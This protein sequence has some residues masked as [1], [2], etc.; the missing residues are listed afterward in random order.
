MSKQNPEQ[1]PDT[2]PANVTLFESDVGE[3]T[4]FLARQALRSFESTESTTA[5][6]NE[7]TPQ[8]LL[9]AL[10]GGIDSTALLLALQAT[11][12]SH[13]FEIH[14]AHFNH[15]LRDKESLEDERYCTKL[16][17]ELQVPFHTEREVAA[18]IQAEVQGNP[19]SENALRQRRYAFLKR[20]TEA[21]GAK[22]IVTGHNLNDQ[23]ETVLFRLVRGTALA[24]ASGMKSWRNIGSQA[25]LL[26]PLLGM[27]RA[28]ISQYVLE[29]EHIAR[30]DSSNQDQRYSRNYIRQ[31]V[32]PHLLERFPSALKKLESFACAAAVDED[33]L[34]AVARKSFVAQ[35]LEADRW[36]LEVLKQM[37]QAILDRIIAQ[38][39][40]QRAIEVSA[41]LIEEI[42]S[43]IDKDCERERK[44][45][46]FSLNAYWD[47]ARRSHY[48]QWL[49][50]EALYAQPPQVQLP[51]K[52]PGT[53]VILPL[54]HFLSITL[55]GGE[56][57]EAAASAIEQPSSLEL[58]TNLT[59]LLEVED[60]LVL[61]RR[62]PGDQF[63]A[64]GHSGPASLKKFLHRQKAA[65]L[66]DAMRKSLD[67]YWTPGQCLVLASGQEVLWIIGVAVSEKLKLQ[68][69]QKARHNI[70][71]G[72]LASDSGA[73]C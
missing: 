47:I 53:T 8:S 71:F 39:L 50:K 15:N 35:N 44:G 19:R 65:E 36:S 66:Q 13:K 63:H 12:G 32:I 59:P 45:V 42:R 56:S 41:D 10:S 1:K 73:L 33:Y 9:V 4:L 7:S 54:N 48:I 26:R 2:T 27:S 49:D 29:R 72:R 68:P 43:L 3:C 28:T 25:W 14:A 21:T 20:T 62:R 17:E 18:S 57:Q 16:C 70:K 60:N 24:G 46:R 31:T 11:R 5:S 37:H 52:T 23:A 51:I 30:T 61:R 67:P 58:N 69:G 64:A 22:F 38:G 55:V 6:D 34:S 40:R